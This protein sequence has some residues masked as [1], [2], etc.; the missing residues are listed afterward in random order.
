MVNHLGLKNKTMRDLIRTILL[1]IAIYSG[2][3]AA[4]SDNVNIAAAAICG[5]ACSVFV[6]T[7]DKKKY[8]D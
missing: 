7:K 3:I 5:A 4:N 8:E 1:T 2:A 6:I